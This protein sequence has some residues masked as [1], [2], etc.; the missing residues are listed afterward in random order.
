V[1]E[2]SLIAEVE[3]QNVRGLLDVHAI[4]QG[5][6]TREALGHEC[7]EAPIAAGGEREAFGGGLVMGRGSDHDPHDVA[8]V[9]SHAAGQCGEIPQNLRWIVELFD[10]LA[11]L[12][13]HG[14]YRP[15]VDQRF[16]QSL[17]ASV[18]GVHG[19]RRHP[20]RGRDLTHRRREVALLAEQPPGRIHRGPSGRLRVLRAAAH[21]AACRAGTLS[22]VA[23]KPLSGV[24]VCY[25]RWNFPPAELA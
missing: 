16:E 7:V 25:T 10:P 15:F 13:D 12:G 14:C 4:A 2:K 22:H 5:A 9:L 19:G 20:G 8:V 18:H 24:A 1:G 3:P 23:S 17:L 21:L 11:C 6:E